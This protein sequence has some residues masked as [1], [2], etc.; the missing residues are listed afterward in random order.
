MKNLK[1]KKCPVCNSSRIRNNR[2]KSICEVCG[3]IHIRTEE[4]EVKWNLYQ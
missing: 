2:D 3:Y 1:I 4:K